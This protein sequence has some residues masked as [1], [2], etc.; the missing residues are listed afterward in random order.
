MVRFS[1]RQRWVDLRV[2][3][4]TIFTPL[5]VH[6]TR[7]T[8]QTLSAG[9]VRPPR[10]PTILRRLFFA[11]KKN[12]IFPSVYTAAWIGHERRGLSRRVVR[13]AFPFPGCF[14]FFLPPIF[15]VADVRVPAIGVADG[16]L[17][18][19]YRDTACG[20]WLRAYHTTDPRLYALPKGCVFA[21]EWRRSSLGCPATRVRTTFAHRKWPNTFARVH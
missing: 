10:P 18:L 8:G 1:L 21:S 15:A 13:R 19:R 16:R 7:T 9:S 17:R 14:F 3:S 4:L 20:T 5:G 6:A 12:Y 2:R 11:K